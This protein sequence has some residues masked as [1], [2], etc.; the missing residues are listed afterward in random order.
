MEGGGKDEKR[1][2]SPELRSLVVAEASRAGIWAAMERY[3]I[4]YGTVRMWQVQEEQHQASNVGDTDAADTDG[5]EQFPTW[6]VHT[7]EERSAALKD[8]ESMDAASAAEKHGVTVQTIRAWRREAT[9]VASLPDETSDS[10]DDDGADIADG[11]GVRVEPVDPETWAEISRPKG[12]NGKRYTPSQRADAVAD[13]TVMGVAAAA[14]KA[15]VSR[16]TLY[17]WIRRARQAAGEDPP[18]RRWEQSEVEKQRDLEI[19]H[20]WHKQPGLGPMQIRS[21]LRRRGVRTSVHTVRRVM[22]DNGY[23]PPKVESHAHHERY[24]AVRPNQLWHLDF[25]HRHIHIAGTFTLILLDDHSRYVTGFE[26]GDAERAN[27]VLET[28]EAAVTRHGRPEAVMSDRGSA[29]RSWRG[30]GRF[31]RLLEEMGVDQIVVE[32]K[33]VNGKVEVFN[34]NLAKELFD[35]KR[36]DDVGRMRAALAEHLHWY[37]HRRTHQA[38]GGLLVP[39]DRYYGRVDE[40]MRRLESDHSVEADPHD[41]CLDARILTLLQVVSRG[42]E[43]EVWL[44]GKRLL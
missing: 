1:Q 40:V 11:D 23:R 43:P 41:P 17:R 21:Q 7:P 33:E 31:T 36:F 20:E 18:P 39:A 14:R 19:L 10:D 13:A 27:T 8:L 24:E 9:E 42:G 22:E 34:A 26:V 25:V 44:L 4:P 29:F 6:R 2:Q 35:T 5:D 38:L 16:H 30:I 32:H 12:A 28:F 15:G 37:N 3:G